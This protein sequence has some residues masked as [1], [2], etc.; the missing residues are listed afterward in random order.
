MAQIEGLLGLAMR[1]GQLTAGADLALREIKAGK[2]ALVL[3]DADASDNTKK[4][5]LDACAFRRVPVHIMEAGLMDRACGREGRM[6]ACLKK[7]GICDQIARII[8]QADTSC[9]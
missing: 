6:A 9:T 5:L 2:A 1:A 3:V 7:G 4:K 8:N